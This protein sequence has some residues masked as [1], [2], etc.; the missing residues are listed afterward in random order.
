MYAKTTINNTTFT[1]AAI[2]HMII[3]V[4]E[5]RSDTIISVKLSQT[6]MDQYDTL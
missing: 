2:S 1:S 3:C 6:E 4:D 5:N